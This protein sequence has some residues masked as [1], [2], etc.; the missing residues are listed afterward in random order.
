MGITRLS[1]LTGKEITANS[2][3]PETTNTTQNQKL[4]AFETHR[5]RAVMQTE[6]RR[7]KMLNLCCRNSVRKKNLAHFMPIGVAG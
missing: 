7:A 6:A 5:S 4:T 3:N 2:N 1:R